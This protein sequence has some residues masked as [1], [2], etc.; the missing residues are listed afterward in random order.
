MTSTQ[1]FANDAFSPVNYKLIVESDGQYANGCY[2]T[3]V[4]NACYLVTANFD[5]LNRMANPIIF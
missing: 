2:A 1:T 3:P 5:S 4:H